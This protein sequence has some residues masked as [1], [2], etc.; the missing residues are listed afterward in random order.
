MKEEQVF[1]QLFFQC[2]NTLVAALLIS[3]IAIVCYLTLKKKITSKKKVNK[4]KSRIIYI[5]TIIFILVVIRIWIEGFYHLFT[6]LSLVGAGL[7]IVNKENIMNF[8]GWIIINWRGLFSEGDFIQVQSHIGEVT[9]IRP[10]YFTLNETSYIGDKKPTGKIVKI[11]NSLII[12]LPITTFSSD[13]NILIH[14]V[15]F[16]VD[17][18]KSLNMLEESNVLISNI[19]KDKYEIDESFKDSKI[20]N[21]RKLLKIG[22][23]NLKPK[24]ELAILS[25]SDKLVQIKIYFYCLAEDSKEIEQTLI[26]SLTNKYCQKLL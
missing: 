10:L 2:F 25:D 15:L 4:I 19:L 16:T 12:T 9:S 7:V 22:V 26:K 17:I 6:M 18:T 5:A 20:L 14:K 13:D 23:N 21:K 8:T 3:L 24:V 1:N 11:P